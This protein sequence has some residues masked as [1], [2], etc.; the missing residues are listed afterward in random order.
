MKQEALWYPSV[1]Q[2]A[3]AQVSQFMQS[4]NQR[5]QA[6]CTDYASLWAWSV[7]QPEAFW[8]SLWDDCAVIGER[9]E[10]VLENAEQ[11]PGA[12]W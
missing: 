11:M 2:V 3:T 10:T 12:R 7:A 8:Q 9:G 6:N 1:E 5:W 4:V